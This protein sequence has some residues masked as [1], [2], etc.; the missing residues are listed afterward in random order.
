MTAI[1]RKAAPILLAVGILAGTSSCVLEDRTVEFVV[2]EESCASLDVNSSSASFVSSP[3]A[4]FISDEI[5]STLEDNDVSREDIVTARIVSAT[6][7][8]TQFT[9]PV[10]LHDWHITG[11]VTVE[12]NDI[13]DGPAA[14]LNYT[15]QSVMEAYGK[16]IA[17]SLNEAG[18]DIVNRA[19]DAY[20]AGGNPVLV[21][22]LSNT[23]VTPTP[24]A[25]DPIVFQWQ[26]C[27]TM[28]IVTKK[29]MQVPDPF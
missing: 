10:S 9:T 1:I 22:K 24:T 4:V 3:A 26:P 28:H 16:K 12:R 17:A 13:A 2:T 23:S 19:I 5:N 14:L 21:F 8:V 29:S 6:Y 25:P 27:V 15:D 20:I 11:S 7:G 18:V